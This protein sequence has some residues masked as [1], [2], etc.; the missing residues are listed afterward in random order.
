[1]NDYT[2]SSD[3]IRG[4]IDTI[5]LRALIDGDKYAQ[6]IMEYVDKISNGQYQLNQATLYSSLKRL[7]SL[8]YVK[9]YWFDA[10]D[11]RR[12]YFKITD[13]GAKN[14]EESLNSW[15]FSKDLIDK[16]IGSTKKPSVIYVE[17]PIEKPIEKPSND[18]IVDKPDFNVFKANNIAQKSEVSDNKSENN[19]EKVIN[20][21]IETNEI[22][23]EINQVATTDDYDFRSVLNELIVTQKRTSNSLINTNENVV[24]EKVSKQSEEKVEKPKKVGFIDTLSSSEYTSSYQSN[25]KIDYSD[26]IFKAEKEG[27]KVK[28]SSKEN[29]K[30]KGTLL[31]NKLNLISSI[32]C[33]L[34]ILLEFLVCI[35][36]FNLEIDFASIYTLSFLGIVVLIPVFFLIAYK[37]KPNK[38]SNKPITKD[39]ILTSLIIVFNLLIIIVALNVVLNVNF[40][41]L[42]ELIKFTLAP[43]TLCLDLVCFFV[44]R[45]VLSRKTEYNSKK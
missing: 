33:S 42:N 3:L 36:A 31:I 34:L 45:H 27:Y 23:A 2:I 28:V 32:G 24:V 41:N 7:E 22:K 20:K 11:G 25:G 44:L 1:M 37:S 18:I 43:I 26:I 5:I 35:L 16:L 9:S 8:N 21:S 40:S 39:S 10:P 17:K 6:I 14:V 4:H 19:A 38:I 29:Y 30:N 13:S 12:K 15:D